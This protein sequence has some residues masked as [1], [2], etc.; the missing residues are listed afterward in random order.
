VSRGETPLLRKVLPHSGPGIHASGRSESSCR[1]AE[2]TQP[3]DYA[4]IRVWRWGLCWIWW[5]GQ[6]APGASPNSGDRLSRPLR[7]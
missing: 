4:M 3:A 5:N 7:R 6:S 1:G 2:T